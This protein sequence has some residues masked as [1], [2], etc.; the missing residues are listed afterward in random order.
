[1]P[2]ELQ[3]TEAVGKGEKLRYIVLTGNES[4]LMREALERRSWWAPAKEGAASWNLWFGGNGQK[5]DFSKFPG[6]ARARQV[7]NRLEAHRE[8]CTKS[9]L[10]ANLQRCRVALRG[11]PMAWAPETYVLAGRGGDKAAL[12]RFKAAYAAHAE[13]GRT[14][15]IVKPTSLNRGNGIEVFNDLKS[16]LAHVDGKP[17]TSSWVV[18]K[19]IERP[20]LVDGRKFDIRAY[21]LVTPDC[22]V[23]LHREAYV[24]T[25]STPYNLTDLSDKAAHLTNDAVQKKL[26]SYH[27][28]E[29][30]CKMG[31]EQLQAALGP[32]YDLQG[33]VWPVMRE[34]VAAVFGA[35][36][37]RMNPR[38]L[39][40]CWELLGL[41]FMIDEEGQAYLIEI[42]TSPAL[43]R[44]GPVLADLL[45][46]VIEECVQKCVDPYFPPP[47]GT[48]A[49]QLPEPL[50]GFQPVQLLEVSGGGSL[51]R[52][53][54]G[55]AAAAVAAVGGSRAGVGK[56]PSL[57]RHVSTGAG[58]TMAR[59]A[60][61]G[62]NG[63]AAGSVW[64]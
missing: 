11:Q 60:S 3:Q 19:Y 16:L 17:A 7:V 30:H 15:W 59:V 29:D 61:V 28:Y 22:Q 32:G 31:M 56:S 52:S 46:R 45:P 13:Q 62:R 37:P 53:S 54:A 12:D 39:Q 10:A 27:Q 36:L 51:N 58:G 1:M 26:D 25:S 50:D 43:F 20:A 48:P 41:D 57:G 8:V 47:A 64:K 18:Q 6:T 4:I 5:F 14:T 44:A 42:N 35:A 9:G 34:A 55:S 21:A 63:E 49:D 38:N 2:E 24:R 33:R 40:F 23:Y